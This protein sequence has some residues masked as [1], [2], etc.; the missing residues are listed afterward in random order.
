MDNKFVLS[1]S[2]N[3]VIFEKRNKAYGAY[4]M[5]RRYGQQVITAVIISCVLCIGLF[6]YANNAMAYDD[7]VIARPIAKPRIVEVP[8]IIPN[9]PLRPRNEPKPKTPQTATRKAAVASAA[10]TSKIDIT[11]EPVDKIPDSKA[12]GDP[13]GETG[14]LNNGP[15]GNQPCDDCPP[16]LLPEPD[17]VKPAAPPIWV[18]IM[19]ANDALW[20]Y[21]SSNV[22]YPQDARERGI[23]GT[24]IIEFIVNKDGTYRDI[25]IA[26]GVCPSIDREALRVAQNMPRW[27]PGKQNGIAVDVLC[28]QPISFKLAK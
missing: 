6:V 25:K 13:N 23:E 26:R 8:V 2:F 17:P 5:R 24:V 22:R 14:G 3:D 16:E 28:R 20:G 9:E 11:K 15:P 10:I 4:Q 1:N 18:E 7:I 19:P 21:L 12:G 27:K